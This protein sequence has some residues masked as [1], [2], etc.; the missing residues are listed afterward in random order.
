[1]KGD[2]NHEA[3]A[4][5]E[6]RRPARTLDVL[7]LGLTGGALL[8][9]GLFPNRDFL[10]DG[11][12]YAY[13][14]ERGQ[15]LFHPHHVLYNP[16]GYLLFTLLRPLGIGRVLGPL[17]LLNSVAGALAIGFFYLLLKHLTGEPRWAAGGAALFGLSFG[18]WLY[19][20][21]VETYT[22]PILFLVVALYLI[23]RRPLS[24]SEPPR[25]LAWQ[26]AVLSA[27]ACLYHQ[28]HIFF[29]PGLAL[30]LWGRLRARWRF[31]LTYLLVTGVL[32]T[33]G[34][35][36][37][38]ALEGQLSSLGTFTYWLTS[39]A[40]RGLWGQGLTWRS[41]PVLVSTLARAVWALPKALLTGVVG[42]A[43]AVLLGLAFVGSLAVLL[44]RRGRSAL[45]ALRREGALAGASA[46]WFALYGGFTFWWQPGNVEFVL[47]LLVPFWML[48]MVALAGRGV[49]WNAPTGRMNPAPTAP[50]SLK[51]RGDG[52][53]GEAGSRPPPG[54]TGHPSPRSGGGP[55]WGPNNLHP[56]LLVAAIAALFLN[57]FLG[58]VLPASHLANNGA[59][60]AAVEISRHLAPDDL[61]VVDDYEWQFNLR[62]FFGGEPRIQAGLKLA[63]GGSPAEREE[64]I[65]ALATAID[66]ALAAGR[67]VVTME[68]D[69]HDIGLLR[70]A[71]GLTFSQAEVE[72][73]YNRY[74]L[75]PLFRLQGDLGFYRAY[76]LFPK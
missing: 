52:G 54:P 22:I 16:T 46:T 69:A 8:L 17:T 62:Y 67:V 19:A 32:V 64:A 57:N 13:D 30:W 63:R 74:R 75:E 50:L 21:S 49:Q 59:Y 70:A 39:Y 38:A 31:L 12:L 5:A 23:A 43:V 44:L 36:V 20:I 1:M 9:F 65:Q 2:S 18:W 56:A 51:G 11:L 72:A 48:V 28:S 25:A 68:Y 26:L 35:L 40:H 24:V 7:F 15:R 61:L 4:G 33:L 6:V 60:G 55:G 10:G 45:A 34:Y 42:R 73:F 37:A 3:M 27:L 66:S 58:R 29:V 14:I 47:P 53:E 71:R 41:I 76:Q